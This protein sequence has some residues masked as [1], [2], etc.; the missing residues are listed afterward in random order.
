M[1]SDGCRCSCNIEERRRCH[2][3]QLIDYLAK[4]ISAANVAITNGAPATPAFH[5]AAHPAANEPRYAVTPDTPPIS[6]DCLRNV[7]RFERG[8]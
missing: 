7:R 4:L 3:A 2:T 5:P 1:E 6:G 8:W